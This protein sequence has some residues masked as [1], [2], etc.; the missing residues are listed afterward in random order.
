VGHYEAG[1]LECDGSPS[2]A[3][4]APCRAYRDHCAIRGI[5]PEVE[6]AATPPDA[7]NALIFAVLRQAPP[8]GGYA[9]AHN[10]TRGWRRF[11]D[12]Y[13]DALPEGV[14]VQASRDVALVGELYVVTWAGRREGRIRAGGIRVRT[15]MKGNEIPIVRYWPTR[16]DRMTPEIEIRADLAR[17]LEVFPAA[18]GIPWRWSE[19]HANGEAKRPLGSLASKVPSERIEDIARLAARALGAGLIRDCRV[20]GSGVEV[21]GKGERS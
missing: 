18:R 12:A 6:K 20:R 3:W 10:S 14:V 21:K 11:L 4:R 16:Y 9:R 2:C 19:K 1:N 15:T 13:V 8:E 5:N 7:L 17:L